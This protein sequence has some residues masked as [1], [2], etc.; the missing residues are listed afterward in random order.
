M[1]I[2]L[3]ILIIILL[4]VLAAISFDVVP[5]AISTFW[6]MKIGT[7]RGDDWFAATADTAVRWSEKGLPRVPKVADKRLTVIDRIKRNY[8]SET[9][10]SWQAGS[11]LLSLNEIAPEEAKKLTLKYI[12]PQTGEWL[13]FINR[14]DSAFLAYAILS[15]PYISADFVKP[16]MTS[17]A[18]MLLNK[19][20][21]FA[22][23]PYSQN[24]N[25]RY[26]DTVGLVCPFLIKYSLTYGDDKAMKAA[27]ALIKEYEEYG[28]HKEFKT[29]VHCFDVKSEAPLGLYSWGRGCGWWATGLAESFKI[30]NETDENSFVEEKIVVLRSLLTFTSVITKY[31]SES[32]AFDR[33]IFAPS[34]ADSSATAMLSYA[35]AYA[36]ELTKNDELT[37]C[38]DKAMKYIYTVTRRNGV[39]DY[40]Q[41]DTMGIGFYSSASVV[42]PATQGFA[43][44]AY[45]LLNK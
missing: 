4:A 24:S 41:G 26:V 39:V 6:R 3:A 8:F 38:A 31:Q 15:S 42:L 12:D 21:K 11:V 30:L 25:Y 36:G 43:L 35:L 37:A 10:Q 16:A 29:P 7:L 32:G 2:L 28:V 33:N 18:E 5:F 20:D 13:S 45:M 9:I 19:Y 22:S 14:V 44:R 34:G 23:I 17:T 40:S 1:K 27:I